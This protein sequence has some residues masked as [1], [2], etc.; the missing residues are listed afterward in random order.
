[1]D[2]STAHST[3]KLFS[4]SLSQVSWRVKAFATLRIL[5]GIVLGIDAWLKW[6]P[7]FLNNF[8]LYLTN[9][10]NGQP[11]FVHSWIGFWLML[12]KTNPSVLAHVVALAESA[13][14]IAV[15]LGVFSNLAYIGGMILTLLIWSTAEG[16]GGPYVPGSTDI[17]PA[18]IYSLVFAGLFLSSAGLYFGVDRLLTPL[19]G[20]WGFLASGRFQ[21]GKWE[22]LLSYWRESGTIGL[23]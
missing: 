12:V 18:I 8:N 22:K 19:L 11:A 6:Q 9:A 23:S 21:L 2:T 1:M 5:F 15:C 17:G 10:M 16:F 4:G 7:T 3:T 20:C 14:A 13:L